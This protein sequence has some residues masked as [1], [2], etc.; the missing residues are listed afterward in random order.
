MTRIPVALRA[1]IVGG[2][3]AGIMLQLAVL[4]RAERHRRPRR[5][6]RR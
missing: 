3:F 2:A 5:P 1:M 4:G 6:C